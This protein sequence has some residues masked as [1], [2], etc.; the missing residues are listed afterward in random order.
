M[1]SLYRMWP[2]H[3]LRHR[4]VRPHKSDGLLGEKALD[5]LYRF[6]CSIYSNTR[7]IECQTSHLIIFD[8][9]A[10]TNTKFQTPI[11]QEIERCRLLRKD[12]WMAEVIVDLFY[13]LLLSVP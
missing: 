11:R 12:R 10:G 6:D 3:E 4:I 9:P 7:R 2:S 13:S 8:F 5:N 1:W